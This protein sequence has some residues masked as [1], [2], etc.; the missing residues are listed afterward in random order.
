M[1]SSPADVRQSCFCQA[2]FGFA[3]LAGLLH[4]P[5][6]AA[7]WWRRHR[8]GRQKKCVLEGGGFAQ[9]R[10][11]HC[12]QFLCRLL[13]GGVY[14]REAPNPKGA[15]LFLLCCSVYRPRRGIA[16]AAHRVCAALVMVV[17]GKR[18]G[19]LFRLLPERARSHVQDSQGVQVC[20]IAA[21]KNIFSHL[22]CF[23]C[24]SFK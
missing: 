2:S 8:H 6:T 24:F 17:W 3:W 23:C 10:H 19:F 1:N 5:S 7:V 12:L 13:R 21:G 14:Q 22:H 20:G 9:S 18:S 4:D 16:K 11:I 15:L